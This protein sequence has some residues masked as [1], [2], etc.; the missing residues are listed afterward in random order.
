MGT[1]IWILTTNA[2]AFPQAREAALGVFAAG[3]AIKQALT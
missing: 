2:R 3:E 1:E